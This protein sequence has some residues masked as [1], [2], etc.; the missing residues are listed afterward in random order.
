[1]RPSSHELAAQPAELE[2]SRRI[3]PVHRLVEE[4][5]LGIPEQATG[6]AQPLTHPQ[7]VAGHTLVSARA[8]PDALE[9]ARDS[10]RRDPASRRSVH[11][12]VLASA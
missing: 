6:D 8:E 12:E 9:H 1:M 10:R 4:Q 7:R 3:E 11:F 5:K 2:H